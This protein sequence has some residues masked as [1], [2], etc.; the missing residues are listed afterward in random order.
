[1]HLTDDNVLPDLQNNTE[2]KRL[3]QA[4]KQSNS[5]EATTGGNEKGKTS[6]IIGQLPRKAH[7]TARATMSAVLEK[8]ILQK[9]VAVMHCRDPRC[10]IDNPDS[11]ENIL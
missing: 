9:T 7:Q 4:S 2:D 1:M 8:R 10:I 5:S 6:G 3:D 11:Q